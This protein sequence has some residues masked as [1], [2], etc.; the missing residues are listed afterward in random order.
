MKV[1]ITGNQPLDRP[2][3]DFGLAGCLKRE[4]QNTRHRGDVLFS[5]AFSRF[6]RR[7]QRLI[8]PLPLTQE[9]RPVQIVQIA[10]R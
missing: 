8:Q 10:E 7:M 5:F 6:R 9:N 4:P 2:L 3:G 1:L